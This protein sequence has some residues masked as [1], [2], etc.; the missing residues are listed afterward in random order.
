MSVLVYP[1]CRRQYVCPSSFAI[2]NPRGR[3]QGF[4]RHFAARVLA[5]GIIMCGL[6][7]CQQAQSRNGPDEVKAEGQPW[8]VD[9]LAFRECVTADPD[10]IAAPAA[11]LDAVRKGGGSVKPLATIT[12]T[13]GLHIW[14][15]DKTPSL[16]TSFNDEYLRQF[17][18]QNYSIS[19]TCGAYLSYVEGYAEVYNRAL[20]DRMDVM[21]RGD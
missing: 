11:Q 12:D 20:A 7:A 5:S 14:G 13:G 10:L 15:E 17:G 2:C 3:G 21:G 16:K 1:N 19:D 4:A 8:P 9:E 6:L 18:W